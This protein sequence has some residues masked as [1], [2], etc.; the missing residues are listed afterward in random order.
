VGDVKRAS[1]LILTAAVLATAQPA[2][3][4]ELGRWLGPADWH[5]WLDTGPVTA[6]S[7]GLRPGTQELGGRDD[8][9]GTRPLEESPGRGN[10]GEKLKAGGLSLLVPGLGQFYN[11]DTGK[12]IVMVG[13]EAVIWGAY[14]GFDSHA[15]NL[16]GD[17]RNWAGIYAGTSGDH[18]ENYW[19]S[20]GRY[21]DSDAWYD[22][23]LRE[24]RAFG[25]PTPPPP[26]SD[27]TWQWRSENY[28]DSY[29]Q[30]RAD[31]NSA[32][33][34]RDLMILFAILNRAVSVFDAVRSGGAPGEEPAM[35]A[36]FLG[37]EVALEVSRP[38]PRPEARAVASWSF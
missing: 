4:G 20:V 30:L 34:R 9:F 6:S 11:G 17:A 12:G 29:Q 32:Y 5:G 15:D 7:A 21:M 19:Q 8:E 1:I 37:G 16:Q 27:E 31:A 22:S 35:G 18:P 36:R 33:D 26:A 24:A 3:A 10:T 23:Q 28:R 38:L 2:A 25:E 13:V 14:L